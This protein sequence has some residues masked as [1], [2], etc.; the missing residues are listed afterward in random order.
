MA[1]SAPHLSSPREPGASIA[2]HGLLG[3]LGAREFLVRYWQKRPLLVRGAWP[4]FEEPAS[5]ANLFR[6]ATRDDCESRVVRRSGRRWRLDHG[7]F[8]RT[9]LRR[10]PA[11][12]WTLLLQGLNHRVPAADRMLRAFSF[13]PYAR[14]DDVMA[15]YAAPGGGV[16]PHVDSYDVFLIQGRGRRRWRISRQRDLELDPRA[17]LKILRNFRPQREWVLGSGD[18][19]YLPPGVA[20]DGT[21]L[22][23][24]VTYSIGFR[25]ASQH[26]LATEFLAFLQDRFRGGDRR[27]ADPDLRSTR[28]PAEIGVDF[29]ERCAA[30]LGRVHWTRTDIERFIGRYFSEPKPHVQ[31]ARPTRPLAASAFLRAC[32]R[33]GLRLAGATGMLYRRGYIYANGE[34]S[35]ATGRTRRL[36]ERLADDRKLAPDTVLTR[37]AASLLYSWYRAGYLVL[38]GHDDG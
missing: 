26:E 17:P 21:A 8:T 25:A 14:L 5:A 20:H 27:Y 35:A 37:E 6:L 31:F 22:D 3:G 12:D 28:R 10:M 18:M 16:G 7:P 34:E 1:R 11:R 15:S 4:Q 2:P 38:E 24:C 9:T 36:L 33:S 32:A 13:I 19:L 23:Q 29:V 30:M